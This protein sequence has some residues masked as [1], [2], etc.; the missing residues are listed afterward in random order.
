ML[1]VPAQGDHRI[2]ALYSGTGRP[3]TDWA[4]PYRIAAQAAIR[5]VG[6]H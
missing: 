1:V 4:A 3:S 5:L 6:S 2:P